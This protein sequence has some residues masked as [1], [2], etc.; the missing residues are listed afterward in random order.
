MVDNNLD[1]EKDLPA[2]SIP[3]ANVYSISPIS[4]RS[5]LSNTPQLFSIRLICK[6]YLL[7]NSLY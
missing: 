6:V 7:S 2:L 5:F 4:L 3:V 1:A